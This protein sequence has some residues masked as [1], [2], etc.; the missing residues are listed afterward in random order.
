MGI[1][2]TKRPA[3]VPP[4]PAAAPPPPAAAPPPPVPAA[5]VSLSKVT[6]TKSAPTVSLTKQ[7]SATG[8]LRVNLNWDAKAPGGGGLFRKVKPLDLDLGCLYEFADGTKGVVQALGNAFTAKPRGTGEN[9]IWLDG[10]DRSGTNTEGENLF[11]NLAHVA[12][13]KRIL[14]FAL[15]YEGA[16]N[17]AAANGVVTLFPAT[18]PQ[19]EVHLDDPRDG[20]RI[21][22]VALLESGGGDLSVRREVNYINGGQRLLD[23]AYGWGMNW[24]PGRK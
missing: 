19:V 3:A 8:L 22:G 23:E 6:L 13:I 10:D 11:V 2:Y 12:Q 7:G 16:A 4:P 24:T 15:I 20:A 17:W 5:P 21:C 14:V 1:D 9:V 18:G